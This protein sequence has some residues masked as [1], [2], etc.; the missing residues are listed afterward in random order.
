MI[1]AYHNKKVAL[2]EKASAPLSDTAIR[3]EK[4]R[5]ES[6][7][8]S[9]STPPKPPKKQKKNLVATFGA[10]PPGTAFSSLPV[11]QCC[12]LN[13]LPKPFQHPKFMVLQRAR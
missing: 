13:S 3:K 6:S 5:K 4:K 7:S 11:L 12:S 9:S 10:V 8:S 1:L 2:R